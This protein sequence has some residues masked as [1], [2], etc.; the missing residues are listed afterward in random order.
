MIT[1]ANNLSADQKTY[2]NSQFN[3]SDLEEGTTENLT[4]ENE[5]AVVETVLSKKTIG[6]FVAIGLIG[7]LFCIVF[8]LAVLYIM[9]PTVKVENDLKG[10]L[11]LP[12][13]GRIPSS[14]TELVE[15]AG[16]GIS[17][18][19]KAN[20]LNRICLI[21]TYSDKKVEEFKNKLTDNVK[22]KDIDIVQCGN[23]FTDPESLNTVISSEGVVLLETIKKS[24]YED[25]AN[26]QELCR[27]YKLNV[28]GTV[29]LY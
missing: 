29:V 27:N 6:K 9:T 3:K 26:V 2:F 16:S 10:A 22:G 7:G 25:I 5:I 28:L 17:A 18:T 19:A 8:L 13:I 15:L 21:S 23:V 11:K 12:V 24:K 1:V 14:K 4:K 20:S